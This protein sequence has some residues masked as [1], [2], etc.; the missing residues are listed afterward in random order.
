[1]VVELTATVMKQFASTLPQPTVQGENLV[2]VPFV[3][4]GSG[5]VFSAPIIP[6]TIGGLHYLGLD[7]GR[8]AQQFPNH[9]TGLM[10]LY[11][12]EVHLDPRRLAAFGRDISL[13][14]EAEYQAIKPPYVLSNFPADLANRGLEYSGIYE[15]GW[16]SE[17]SF[18][19]LAPKPDSRYLVIRGMVP[20]IDT[21]DFRNT[22]A[23]SINGKEI[24]RQ[25]LGLGVF[26]VKVP[27]LNDLRHRIDL[28]FDRYQVLPGTDGRPIGGKI[29]FIGFV[30]EGIAQ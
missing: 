20:K 21:P 1:M 2:T 24:I 25:T 11:G 4:R 15:D 12:R 13:V 22:L 23:V 28:A 8:D 3:G 6:Q 9:L 5:R 14:S 29:E 26:E 27:V 7:M 16:I 18:F 30:S 10:L 19:I 17:R